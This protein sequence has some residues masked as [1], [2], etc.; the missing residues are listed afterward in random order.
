MARAVHLYTDA[1]PFVCSMAFMYAPK[2]SS[3]PFLS[4]AIAACALLTGCGSVGVGIGVPLFPG[5]SIG[6]GVGSGGVYGGVAAGAGPVGVGVGVNSQ[7]QVLGSAGVGVSTGVGGNASVGVGVGTST[8]L[9]DPNPPGT[10]GPMP[11]W[12]HP[13]EVPPVDSQVDYWR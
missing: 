7:G 1:R 3:K 2:L 4:A 6:V 10:I 8:V 13:A 11:W 5:V 12:A 9:H